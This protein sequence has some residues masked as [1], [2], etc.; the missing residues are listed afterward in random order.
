MYNFFSANTIKRTNTFLYTYENYFTNLD[1]IT[2]IFNIQNFI[3]Y[4]Y[5][6]LYYQKL[7]CYLQRL[8]YNINYLIFN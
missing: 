1:M 3:I 2:Q 7:S 6:W 8:D 4:R 5:S